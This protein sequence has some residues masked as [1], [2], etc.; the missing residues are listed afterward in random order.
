MGLCLSV[1]PS[2]RHKSVS[3]RNDWTNRAVF[4]MWAFFHPSYTVL[5]GNPIISKNKGTSLWNFVLNSGLQKLQKISPWHIDCRNVLS[6]EPEK[7]GRSERD[8]LGR[9]RSTKSIIRST[10]IVYRTDRQALSTARF[11]HT[12]QLATADAWFG[13]CHIS[14]FCVVAWQLARFQLT[15]RI[16][17][18]LGDSWASC[19]ITSF[20]VFLFLCCRKFLH[21]SRI[22]YTFPA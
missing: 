12:S 20:N 10:T 18:S 6:T 19:L 5:K 17:R 15:R 16:A 9:R 3:Y 11:C 21:H 22:I 8:K 1:C 7:G 13:T 4:G 14:S 2:V